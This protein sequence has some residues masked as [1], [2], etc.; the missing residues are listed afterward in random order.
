MVCCDD[1]VVEA[2]IVRIVVDT[3]A[4]MLIDCVVNK[5]QTCTLVI[6][7]PYVRVVHAAAQSCKCVIMALQDVLTVYEE[8]LSTVTHQLWWHVSCF[9][10]VTSLGRES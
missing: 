10:W 2:A 7:E 5:M 6:G 4:S 1:V 9:Q 3:N 8:T